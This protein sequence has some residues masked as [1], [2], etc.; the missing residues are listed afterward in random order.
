MGSS[1]I[2][3]QPPIEM[4]AGQ[5]RAVADDRRLVSEVLRKDR[6][7]T[8][9]FVEL[10]ADWVYPYLRWRV[11]PHAGLV[12]DLMQEIL[13]AAWQSL[14]N[15]HGHAGLRAW[16]LGIARHKV[17]DYYRKRLREMIWQDQESVAEEPAVSPLLDE[18]L[19]TALRQEKVQRTLADMPEIYA[20]ALLWRYRD[21]RPL[22]EMAQLTGKT[23][24]AMERLLARAREYFRKRWTDAK[25]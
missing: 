5:D 3:M 23:E 4:P 8:A 14:P 25:S 22:R 12:E 19:D 21:D 24:K 6:K 1:L 15:F 2:G 13:L 18:R 17:E 9:K 11:M 10:C 7:A 16:I 20:L